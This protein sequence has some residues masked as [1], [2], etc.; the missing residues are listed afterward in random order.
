MLTRQ[1]A[2]IVSVEHPE[3][4]LLAQLLQY[5]RE[6]GS[7]DIEPD[8][9]V[10]Y[11]VKLAPVDTDYSFGTY[12]VVQVR[13]YYQPYIHVDSMRLRLYHKKYLNL[14]TASNK[15]TEALNP[16]NPADNERLL[17]INTA[18]G[19]KI[20]DIVCRP[21]ASNQTEFVGGDDSYYQ[22]FDITIQYGVI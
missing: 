1:S 16:E 7:V 17:S 15:L 14:L 13:D 10:L 6:V 22:D 8:Q 21:I 19:V 4:E 11:P 5:I 9:F 18:A 12:S 20:Q 3:I 2:F